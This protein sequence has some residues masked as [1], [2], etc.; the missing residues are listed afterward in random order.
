MHNTLYSMHKTRALIDPAALAH[1]LTVARQHA[2]GSR[3]MAVVK[4]DAYGH[5]AVALLPE[6]SQHSDGLAVARLSEAASLRDAGYQG[7]LLLLCG[8]MDTAEL[9]LAYQYHLDLVVHDAL[10]VALLEQQHRNTHTIALWPKLDSG[11]H[12]LGFTPDVFATV[13]Q[14]LRQLP[15]CGELVA[16]TH[17]ACADE[18]DNPRTREQLA[19]FE[20]CVPAGVVDAASL[21]NSAGLLAWPAARKEWVRPGLM[22]YGSSPVDAARFP[23]PLQPVMQLQAQ[24]LACRDIAAGETVGYNDTWRATRNSRIAYAGIGYAD[25]YP[26]VWHEQTYVAFGDTRL[27]VIGRVSMDTIALDCTDAP[28]LPHPGDWVELWGQHINVADV[29]RWVGTIP[30]QLLTG[31]SARVPKLYQRASH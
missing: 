15:C 25:G 30:Y 18:P 20:Q 3:L 23:A 28:Q 19:C 8:V 17:F 14:Q 5:G 7:R 2:H 29:A 11:M 1:N 26:V 21:A 4:A 31:V 16:M 27:P 10:Q 24:V 13:C 6:L 9:Q 22:L 12:R